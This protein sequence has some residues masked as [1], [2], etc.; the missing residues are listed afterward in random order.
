[1][2]AAGGGI[3]SGFDTLCT[4]STSYSDIYTSNLKWHSR[5]ENPCT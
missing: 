5:N 4:G 3:I 1:M 2:L